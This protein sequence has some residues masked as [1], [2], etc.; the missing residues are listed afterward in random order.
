MNTNYDITGAKTTF[1]SSSWDPGEKNQHTR[2]RFFFS[3]VV[4]NGNIRHI[5]VLLRIVAFFLSHQQQQ[6]CRVFFSVVSKELQRQHNQGPDCLDFKFPQGSR[7]LLS[8]HSSFRR[9]MLGTMQLIHTAGAGAGT[10]VRTSNLFFLR[11]SVNENIFVL[12]FFVIGILHHLGFAIVET[13]LAH[14]SKH[15]P[16]N[17]VAESCE[18]NRYTI[19]YTAG[20]VN[21]RILRRV[22]RMGHI[23]SARCGEKGVRTVHLPISHGH[24][25]T[26]ML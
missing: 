24:S 1:P 18:R 19:L 15:T 2:Q 17:L 10:Y 25:P 14:R 9:T 5:I 16:R 23:N 21:E 12:F 26:P 8:Q 20:I 22:G 3:C 4:S 6:Q 7:S 13:Q 11:R